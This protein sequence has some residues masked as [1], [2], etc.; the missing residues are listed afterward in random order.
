[1]TPGDLWKCRRRCYP[2]ANKRGAFLAHP[3]VRTAMR[4]LAEPI[5]FRRLMDEGAS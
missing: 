3:L 5:R 2:I 4:E 1:M